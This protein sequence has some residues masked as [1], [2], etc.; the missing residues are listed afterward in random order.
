MMTFRIYTMLRMACAREVNRVRGH[1]CIYKN[2]NE[3]AIKWHVNVSLN[4]YTNSAWSKIRNIFHRDKKCHVN[5]L[6]DFVIIN[7]MPFS[8]ILWWLTY[9]DNSNVYNVVCGM[10]K[11][12]KVYLNKI[13]VFIQTINRLHKTIY[14]VI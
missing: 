9:D 3:F 12:Y 6:V 14:S 1:I 8:W 10:W 11:R 7:T 2:N 4:N 5:I 13:F